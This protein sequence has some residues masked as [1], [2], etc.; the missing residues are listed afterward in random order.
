VAVRPVP[1]HGLHKVALV[2]NAVAVVAAS[3]IK[4]NVIVQISEKDALPSI[5]DVVQSWPP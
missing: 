3:N 2:E 1:R 5:V 4:V